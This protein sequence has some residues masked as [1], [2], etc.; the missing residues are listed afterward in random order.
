MRVLKSNLA[1][2]VFSKTKNAEPVP[3][4]EVPS[5]KLVAS[6]QN[7]SFLIVLIMSDPTKA[8][9]RRVIRETWLSVH[10]NKVRH[11]FVVGSKGLTEEVRQGVINENSVHHDLLILDSISESY[12]SLT[13]KVLTGIQWLHSNYE[14]NF[15]LKCDDD[16]FVRI[17][18]LL[19][20]LQKQPQKLLYWGFFKG[21]ST[22]FQKGK[23]KENGWFLCDT[24]LPYA[25]GGG[26]I[27]SSDLVEF[28]AKCAPLLQHYK[29]EDVSVGVWLSPLKI[30]R[31]HDVRFD[32]EFKSRGCYN[33]YL[34]T[35]KQGAIDMRTKHTN[36]IKTGNLCPSELR[37]RYSYNYNWTVPPSKCCKN[38][39]PELP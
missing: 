35:H 4:D 21:G 26:Y 5:Q 39:D 10:N 2:I 13:G 34:I 24:Y 6:T 36:L 20:E 14:F 28:L 22:V 8:A 9:T 18:P 33:D 29:S 12:T 32:T 16:S 38:F 15:L 17:S 7:S 11:F 23:W 37:V 25:L 31:V 27:L 1:I 3:P 19:E 30:H